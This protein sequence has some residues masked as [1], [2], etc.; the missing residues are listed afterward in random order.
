MVVLH[1]GSG[2]YRDDHA[3]ALH[4][5][6]ASLNCQHQIL[7]SAGVWLFASN[8]FI[9]LDMV[10]PLFAICASMVDVDVHVLYS[11]LQRFSI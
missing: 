10:R 8:A 11:C 4:V 7:M 2:C 6:A 9:S 1:V 3:C 5:F